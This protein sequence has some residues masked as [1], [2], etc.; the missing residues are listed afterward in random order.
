LTDART[1][2]ELLELQRRQPVHTRE[3]PHHQSVER[4]SLLLQR[5]RGG[6]KDE[7]EHG[8]VNEACATRSPCHPVSATEPPKEKLGASR[9]GYTHLVRAVLTPASK[10]Q[11][12]AVDRRMRVTPRRHG[13]PSDA[14]GHARTPPSPH[15]HTARRASPAPFAILLLLVAAGTHGAPTGAWWLKIRP[16]WARFACADLSHLACPEAAP[17]DE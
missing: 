8:G 14:R 12:R 16:A 1:F 10:N 3:V 5:L 4:I 9:P 13:P 6:W 15:T 17:D 2:G 11:Y 7:V